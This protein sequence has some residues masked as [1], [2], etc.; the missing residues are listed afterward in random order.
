MKKMSSSE[1][2]FEFPDQKPK[3]KQ[4]CLNT[5]KYKKIKITDEPSDE[6]KH[7]FLIENQNKKRDIYFI[8]L[9]AGALKRSFKELIKLEYKSTSISDSVSRRIVYRYDEELLFAHAKALETVK[10]VIDDSIVDS[11]EWSDNKSLFQ[12]ILAND[13]LTT[14]FSR[15][16]AFIMMTETNNLLPRHRSRY[17]INNQN[18][19]EERLT[20]DMFYVI[21]KHLG[22]LREDLVR[23]FIDN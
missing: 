18:E 13:S 14:W 20:K 16:V 9:V 4:T 17:V 2:E 5:K 15:Y 11:D 3:R 8:K 7:E 22:V 12:K 19:I 1:N 21:H 10:S 6:E 23:D